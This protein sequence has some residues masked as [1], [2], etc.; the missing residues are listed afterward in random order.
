MI[1]NRWYRKDR[2]DRD[3]EFGFY[4]ETTGPLN[5]DDIVKIEFL[6]D[7]TFKPGSVRT[8]PFFRQDEVVEIGPRLQIET[9]DSSNAVSIC[10]NMGITQVTRF[11]RTRRHRV[12]S[13]DMDELKKMPFDRMTEQYFENGIQ[14]FD[15]GKTADP[16]IVVDL[17]GQG[18]DELV[19]LNKKR[20]WS[21]DGSDIDH[22]YKYFVEK[23]KRNPTMDEL[24]HVGNANSDHS[25][26][27]LWKSLQNI[28]GICYPETLLD[29]VK[30]PIKHVEDKE[31]SISPFADD[32]GISRGFEVDVLIPDFPGRPSRLRKRKKL[33]HSIHTAET[34]NH[35]SAVE[36]YEGAAT[37]TGGDI[38]DK[39]VTGKGA[40]AGLGI[41]GFL[42]GAL[43][44]P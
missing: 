10:H 27:G 20:G 6:I 12:K 26:H 1:I 17:I 24:T 11:E 15:S 25:R 39:V 4:V 33:V 30:E 8:K 34:H 42:N 19:R 44:H 7:E 40:F 9:P 22:Y 23:L 36:P 18:I 5:A 38:R 16:V 41:V 37:G 28:A 3:L 2:E 31:L 35:P 43:F 14:S 32:S 21:M 29:A 13:G